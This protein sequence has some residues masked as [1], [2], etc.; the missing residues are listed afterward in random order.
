MSL[1]LKIK[2]HTPSQGEP[3]G[4]PESGSCPFNLKCLLRDGY[5]VLEAI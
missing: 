4:Y 5:S 2:K 1:M 3:L